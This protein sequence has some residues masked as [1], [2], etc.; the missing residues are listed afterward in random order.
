L[1]EHDLF[2]KP[3]PTFPDHALAK[4][5]A[6]ACTKQTVFNPVIVTRFAEVG[7]GRRFGT[8]K[9]PSA[10]ALGLSEAD[11]PERRILP[12]PCRFPVRLNRE[13]GHVAARGEADL[14]L[15]RGDEEMPKEMGAVAI[16]RKNVVG[17]VGA[18]WR[19]QRHG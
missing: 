9:F 2:G 16:L 1:F 11:L 6:A 10:C 15:A 13:A 4:P 8:N 14:A 12:R 7:D 3:V 5:V 17:D 19:A 18:I